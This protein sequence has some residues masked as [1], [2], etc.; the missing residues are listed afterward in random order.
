VILHDNEPRDVHR[1][2]HPGAT[3]RRAAAGPT[4]RPAST[5]V[6]KGARHEYGCL[7]G[8]E[9]GHVHSTIMWGPIFNCKWPGKVFQDLFTPRSVPDPDFK[10]LDLRALR[11][12]HP[13]DSSLSTNSPEMLTT[14]RENPVFNGEDN[15]R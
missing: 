10:P 8:R 4:Y 6:D 5:T 7:V 3:D 9:S 12:E 2:T 1:E 15:D 14:K 13:S 11:A